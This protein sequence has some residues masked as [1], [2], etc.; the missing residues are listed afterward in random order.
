MNT[1]TIGR[2]ASTRGV[3]DAVGPGAKVAVEVGGCAYCQDFAGEAVVGEDPLPP[4]HPS[5]TC[6]ATAAL[7]VKNRKVLIA[8]SGRIAT[9]LSETA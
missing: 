8:R 1:E 5:C 3:V 7:R 6:V 9:T 2:Q 4:F